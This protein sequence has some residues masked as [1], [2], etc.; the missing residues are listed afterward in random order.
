MLQAEENGSDVCIEDLV[1]QIRVL[2]HDRGS[3][4]LKAG[5]VESHIKTPEASKRSLDEVRYLVIFGDIS[6][7]IE[8]V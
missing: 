4:L 8:S 7:D 5:I 1:E 6:L 3:G 2:R